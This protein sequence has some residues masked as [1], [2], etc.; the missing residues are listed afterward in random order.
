[1]RIKKIILTSRALFISAML[2]GLPITTQAAITQGTASSPGGGSDTYFLNLIEQH[3]SAILTNVNNLP[4]YLAAL[5]KLA[6]SLLANDDSAESANLQASFGALT[7]NYAANDVLQQKIQKQLLTDF[8][9]PNVTTTTVPYANDMT[10][11]TFVG[12][13]YFNPDP[14]NVGGVKID[15]AYNYLKNVAGLNMQHAV[16]DP[17]WSGKPGAK[18]NY[19]NFYSAISAVQTYNAYVLSQVYAEAEN[20]NQAAST[21]AALIKL[22]SDSAWFSKIATEN[23][24]IVLR[25]ILMYNSQMYIVMTQI[26]QA[27]KQMVATQAMNNT[28]LILGNTF[29]ESQLLNKATGT[30]AMP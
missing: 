26:L 25:Q 18:L 15:Y 28:L 3:T 22:A 19:Q 17:G 5:T 16:P 29:T 4:S 8:F 13:P 27:Q 9:G 20:N 2:S 23:I 12:Q 6:L 30:N 21:Q 24:G 10:F 1:M 14:R 7:N 11:Q